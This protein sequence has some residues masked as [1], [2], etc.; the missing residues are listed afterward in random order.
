MEYIQQTEISSDLKKGVVREVGL[1]LE[2]TT[3]ILFFKKL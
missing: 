3:N 2:V 1:S